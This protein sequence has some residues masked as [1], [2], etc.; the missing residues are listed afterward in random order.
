MP[1]FGNVL[2]VFTLTPWYVIPLVW[3]P[4]SA[5][6]GYLA[7]GVYS[8]VALAVLF[9]IGLVHWTLVEYAVHRFIF[10]LDG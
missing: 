4:V 5:L 9:A 3:L 7:M 6:W 1:V 10:H 8:P 2:E